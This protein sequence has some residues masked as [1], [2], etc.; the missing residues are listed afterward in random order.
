MPARQGEREQNLFPEQNLE[1][2][3][4][5][6]IHAPFLSWTLGKLDFPQSRS[7]FQVVTLEYS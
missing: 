5:G 3:L 1:A 6:R 7:E 4:T 2:R